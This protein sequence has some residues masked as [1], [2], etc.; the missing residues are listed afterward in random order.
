MKKLLLTQLFSLLSASF[1]SQAFA[2]DEQTVYLDVRYGLSTIKSEL[3]ES[4]ETSSSV[5]YGVG[6]NAGAERN[7]GVK[8][9]RESMSTKFLLNETQFDAT[10]QDLSFTYSW[11][12]MALGGMVVSLD[13]AAKDA[14]GESIFTA[15]A[16]GYGGIFSLDIPVQKG[17][18]FTEAR[19]ATYS[20]ITEKDEKTLTIGPRMDISFG[21]KLP[22]T[23]RNLDMVFGYRQRTYPISLEGTS[24]S[25]WVADTFLGFQWGLSF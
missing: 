17:F 19:F 3:L 13:A 20:T 5:G 25:E 21:G 10:W 18:F 23:K 8:L 2:G 11:G 24:A 1:A 14:A 4:N 12:W 9:W 6:A 22:L 16:S 15:V 7:F